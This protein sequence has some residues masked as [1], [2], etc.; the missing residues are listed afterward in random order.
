MYQSRLYNNGRIARIR[1]L[2]LRRVLILGFYQTSRLPNYSSASPA[3]AS[4]ST[5]TLPLASTNHRG[6]FDDKSSQLPFEVKPKIRSSLSALSDLRDF[7]TSK[8]SVSSEYSLINSFEIPSYTFL[9]TKDLPYGEVRRVHTTA[10]H[11][12][13]LGMYSI[14][15]VLMQVL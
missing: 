7:V 13:V 11:H 5:P 8:I 1:S 9:S 2:T 14:V 12:D 4:K 6:H 10:Y 15:V 3:A